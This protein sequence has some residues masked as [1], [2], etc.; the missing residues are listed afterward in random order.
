[1]S[2]KLKV[3]RFA[4]TALSLFIAFAAVA[5]VT[6]SSMSGRI[7]ETDGTPVI[8]AAVVAVHTPS[9]TKY[10][11][12]TDITGNYRIQNM[13]VGG[14]YTIEI[15]YLGYGT[16]KAENLFL[17]LGENFVYDARLVEEAL[18]LSEIVVSAGIK[19]PI[20]NADRT[21][22]SL[23][24]SSRELASLPTISRSIMD[25]TR[26][27]P[28]AN[29]SSFAGRD[30]RYNTVT[31]DG[32]AFNNNFGLSSNVMPGGTSQ[33]ISLDAIEQVSVNLAPYDVRQSRFTGAAINAVTKS[34]DNTWR[35]TA[36]TYQ[37][38]KSFTGD[39]VGDQTVK[40]ARD[41]DSQTY[42][43]TFGGPIVKDKLFIFASFES[44][45]ENS[46]S[47]G[48]EPSTNGVA[49]RDERISRTTVADLERMKQ[50]LLSTYGYDPGDYKDFGA[51]PYTN[52]KVLARLDWNIAQNHKFALRYNRL[53][54]TSTT[55]TNATS[56]PP[57]VPRNNNSRISEYSI[58]FSNS[59]YGS[60]NTIDA[61]AAELNSTF[62]NRIANKLLV[63]YTAT[64]DPKRTSNSEIFPFVDIYE[65]GNPY[66]SFGYELFS[67]RNQ[68]ENNTFSIV[69]NLTLN[70][71]KHTLTAGISYDNIYVNNSYIRE[72]TSYYRYNSMDDFI[73]NVKPAGF[74][75]TY[76]Y[77]G[78]DPRG[79]EMSFG[80]GSLY[81]QDEWMVNNNFKL[82]YGLRAEFPMYHNELMGNPAVSAL[83]FKDGYKLDLASWPTSKIQINPRIGFNWDVKGDRS[84]Q[85]RGGTGLFAGVLPFV[86]F[87][88]QPSSSG[89]IQSP[90][91]G[92]VEANLPAD[93]RF[94]K[95]FRAQVAKYPALFPQAVSTTLASGAA[96]AEVSKDFKMPRVWRTNL[97]GD[98]EL[99]GNMALTL[100]ALFTKDLNS[101]VQQNVNLASPSRVFSGPD[102][103]AHYWNPATNKAEGNKVVSSTSTV[104]VL[105]NADAGY[106][107][108]L[109]AQLTKNFSYGFSGMLAYTYN[110]SKD[111]SANPGSAAPSA[112]QSNLDVY[113]L[114]NPQLSYSSF[115]VPH[116]VVGSL[117]YKVEYLRH[118]A[119]TFSI[120]YN[121][122]AMGRST[123][124]YSNDM[125][126]DGYASDIL[127]IPN[128]ASD[129][130]FVDVP[131]KMT[132]AEQVAKFQE[133]LDNDPYLSKRKGEYAER[134]GT[135]NPWRN[136]W[137]VKVLQDIFAKFGSGRKYTLQLSL[138]IVNA[139]NLLNKDWGAFTR[140][141]L[142]NQY[143][144][145]MPLTYKGVNHL[146]EPTFTLNATDIANFDAKNKQIK[147][148]TIS[149]TWGML[150]GIRLIF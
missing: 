14:P 43:F 35:A 3:K 98:F 141:G 4:L 81:L 109:T 18:T 89:T 6:T 76:G 84:V 121:G 31:I 25:F 27:T 117:S 113:D 55:L 62:G 103:R 37:R 65:D 99:P 64:T 125:T 96:L 79:V 41:K 53:R 93:F 69:N 20:L 13:R 120:Y 17:R 21:G 58:S 8:G 137:D 116:R 10:Y 46:P 45:K 42:G 112:W 24:V 143:D 148:T 71:D 70:L 136:S 73:N 147:A 77:G 114:N 97:A 36:Y 11:S 47:S 111:L 130:T 52:Y 7:T 145:I 50:H 123:F 67:Y 74:G 100:E 144:V 5:Q 34:G 82:T 15:A 118:L 83:T 59:F 146:G 94:N 106:Q 57:N 150:F 54:N 23:N 1:M 75:I 49:I 127:Y 16:I 138:D 86:W 38:P 140:S 68:V 134:F 40:G 107:A 19:N 33:P 104:M 110:I 115:A 51:F 78:T 9:G 80:L 124:A 142:A 95:D 88:N 26:M 102:K 66:M 2:M 44:E 126:G 32:A 105:K 139:A 122:A 60:E 22:A 28:Q 149:S 129:L 61:F 72:G 87:T 29:G 91:L 101:I 90:E 128:R 132:V 39:K 133:F 131:G 12:I 119:T 108:L 63:S 135:V 30:G 48:W 85:V 56:G 92:I